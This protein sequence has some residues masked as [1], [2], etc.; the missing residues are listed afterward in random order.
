MTSMRTA[1]TRVLRASRGTEAFRFNV[2]SRALHTS[3][4]IP[5][6]NQWLRYSAFAA[7]GTA[8]ALMTVQQGF[9][10]S[11]GDSRSFISQAT[12]A[13]AHLFSPVISKVEEVYEYFAG[14]QSVLLKPQTPDAYGRRVRT[15]VLDFDGTLVH[16][17]WTRHGGWRV[18]KRPD[19]DKFIE[20]AARSGYEVVLWSSQTQ[21][22]AEQFVADFDIYGAFQHKL[23]RHDCNFKE[24]GH[25][26]DLSRLGRDLKNVIAIDWRG[27]VYSKLQPDNCI[28]VPKFTNDG[29]D[30]ELARLSKLL[31]DIIKYNVYDTRDI[32]KKYNADPLADHFAEERRREQAA[33]RQL[34]ED[35]GV[36]QSKKLSSK[37]S[38][39]WFGGMLSNKK[40]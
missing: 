34:E 1:A 12:D 14:D 24:G 27:K 30:K 36:T 16:C 26:K 20:K 4:N 29:N 38:G 35:D 15:I 7:A 31:E 22:D 8:I 40:K 28:N 37:S 10:D 33:L 18:R 11:D 21:L 6:R 23:Y 25:V 13:A 5:A 17:V 19:V 39:G 2:T 32:I 3:P 9:A